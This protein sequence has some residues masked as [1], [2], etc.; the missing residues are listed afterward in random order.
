MNIGQ[1]S[2]KNSLFVNLLTVFI[3][4][5]GLTAVAKLNREAF[6][7][8]SRDVVTVQTTYSGSPAREVENL[9]TIP[10]EEEVFEVD[11][12][13][14][15]R[16]VSTENL[17]LLV[18][19]ID[20][21]VDDKDR[22]VTDIQRAVDR[23]TDL[24]SDAEDPIVKEIQT[25]NVPVIELAVSGGLTE[26]ELQ[27]A[28]KI[29]EDRLRDIEGVGGVKRS[30]WHDPEIW[31]EVDPYKLSELHVSTWE[32]IEALKSKNLNLPAGLLKEP[33]QDYLIR[34][35]G[36]FET[37]DE[38]NEVI[39]RAND[40]G[41]WIRVKDVGRARWTFEDDDI[42]H[43]SFGTQAIHLS[44]LKRESGDIIN[45]VDRVREEVNTFLKTQDPRIKVQTMNDLS[46]FVKRRLNVLLSNGAIGFILVVA[47]LVAMMRKSAALMTA[48]GIPVAVC[49]ALVLMSL[50][51]FTI[52]LLTMFGLIMVLGMV[53]DDAIV[54]SENVNRHM[55]MGKSPDQAAIDGTNEV[56]K[57]VTA[58]VL[59]T[60]A[61]FVPLFFMKGLMGK[62]IFFIPAVVNVTLAASLLEALFILPSHLADLAKLAEKFGWHNPKPAKESHWFRWVQG[63]YKRLLTWVMYH[64][65]KFVQIAVGV[66]ILAAVIYFTSMSYHQFPRGLIEEFFIRAEA[67]LG[68][69]LEETS[70]RMEEIEK[71]VS[72]LPAKELDAYVTEVGIVQENPMDPFTNRGSHLGQVHVFLTPEQTRERHAR[73]IIA[74]LRGKTQYLVR[75]PTTFVSAEGGLALQ[76]KQRWWDHPEASMS[77]VTAPVV[78][79]KPAV[80]GTAEATRAPLLRGSIPSEAEAI[81]RSEIAWSTPGSLPRNDGH[82]AIASSSPGLRPRSDDVVKML[83]TYASMGPRSDEGGFEKIYFDERK[84]GPPVGAPLSI[85]LR[86]TDYAE[87]EAM[88]E[89]IKSF[90]EKRKGVFDVRDD[91]EFGKK[92]YRIIVDE[93]KATRS[94]LTIERIAASVRHGF[95]GGVATTIKRSDEEIDVRV[96][97]PREF[98]E[99]REVFEKIEVPNLTGHLIPLSQVARFEIRPNISAIKHLDRKRVLTVAAEIDEKK[100]S[101]LKENRAL[102]K[103]IGTIEEKYPNVTVRYGGEAEETREA[104][105][106]FKRVFPLA[107]LL[108]FVILAAEFRSILQPLVVMLTIPFGLVGV[109]FAF[110]LHFNTPLSFMAV[111]GMIGLSGIVVNDAIVLVDFINAERARGKVKVEAI[112]DGAALR[113]RPVLL[114]TVT[115]VLGLGPVAYG[116]GG[117]DPFIKPM[118]LAIS[119]GLVF[120]TTLTLLVIPCIYSIFDDASEKVKAWFR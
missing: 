57:P 40:A 48:L 60:I 112:I 98:R 75:H 46:Y 54:I 107:L 70:K 52:N 35:L 4:L 71:M 116:I 39:I 72:E 80:Q 14:E 30:G 79:A 92:E 82:D 26:L 113:L 117:N 120:S 32:V 42:I 24:P 41:N 59:T 73:E 77:S 88:A 76:A 56:W 27:E 12:I 13:E 109:V 28:A 87:L 119:W 1:F 20:P 9:I 38:V 96:R 21:D 11:G 18:I 101:S 85:E 34:T 66:V 44:V 81:S 114:T 90:L 3:L 47:C 25:K 2:V 84:G 93:E 5:A 97:F 50:V 64:R 68:T 100:T 22:V 53:V 33:G 105:G 94:G 65:Y 31:V 102:E 106:N 86:G 49:A 51:G 103:L 89:E 17:S 45:I 78:I 19:E 55:E 69:P 15:L 8:I 108:I 23:V 37:P 63:A 99:T 83:N 16:S 29:L 104:F 67:P 58:T 110:F 61:A 43:K 7:N 111:L 95:E 10:L 118:A 62:Y 115:T 36:E 74:E 6:P 91:Y